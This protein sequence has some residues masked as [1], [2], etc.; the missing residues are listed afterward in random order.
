MDAQH[1]Q[2]RVTKF[3]NFA[4]V[5]R[6]VIRDMFQI[7]VSFVTSPLTGTGRAFDP[8]QRSAFPWYGGG[9]PSRQG[10]IVGQRGRHLQLLG[11]FPATDSQ[12][13]EKD[14]LQHYSALPEWLIL[15]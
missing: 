5:F 12:V 14:P 13:S 4:N 9:L 2:N 1:D 6:D 3:A 11:I 7:F 10:H 15:P 8:S